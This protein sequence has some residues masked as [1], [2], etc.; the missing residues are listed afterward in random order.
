MT[1]G[2]FH[3]PDNC[4]TSCWSYMEDRR[5]CRGTM[6]TFHPPVRF[7]QSQ[8]LEWHAVVFDQRMLL[9][10]NLRLSRRKRIN[11]SPFVFAALDEDS[12]DCRGDVPTSVL[13]GIIEKISIT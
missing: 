2:L 4:P 11:H 13:R 8:V 1:Q 7:G 3:S 6:V 12:D 9:Q 5:P 10:R